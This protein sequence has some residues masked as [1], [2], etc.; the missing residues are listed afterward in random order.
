MT[1]LVGWDSAPDAAGEFTAVTKAIEGFEGAGAN[2][3]A[4]GTPASVSFFFDSIFGTANADFRVALYEAATRELVAYSAV[5]DASIVAYDSVVTEPVTSVKNVVSGTAYMIAVEKEN[6]GDNLIFRKDGTTTTAERFSIE[7]GGGTSGHTQD[8]ASPPPDP[9]PADDS[10]T[11]ANQDPFYI[12]FSAAASTPTQE[13]R[14]SSTFDIETALG[15]ITTATLNAV[16]VFDH[17][18]GQAG[19]TVSFEGAATDEITTSGE[20]TLTLGD[21]TGTE[22]ITVQVNVYGVVPSDNPWQKE[23]TALADLTNVQYR[24]VAGLDLNGTELFYTGTGTT[25]ASGN[26]PT[27]D[28]SDSAADVDDTVHIL[29]LTANGESIIAPET[30]ELI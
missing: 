7:E 30:V 20:Y 14:K 26:I 24:V 21:G 27:F 18:T 15:T 5:L 6:A 25:N 12:W 29:G 3:R 23:G 22:D 16:N 10:A 19:T 1:T 4:N 9:M 8:L 13:I 11:G 2:G 17:I 28:V